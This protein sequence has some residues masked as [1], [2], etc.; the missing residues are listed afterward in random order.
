[1]LAGKKH[2]PSIFQLLYALPGHTP[3]DSAS[4]G[5]ERG[6][7]ICIFRK[8]TKGMLIYSQVWE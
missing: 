6:L 7:S 8:H 1:M 3:W 2:Y 4:L 5:L